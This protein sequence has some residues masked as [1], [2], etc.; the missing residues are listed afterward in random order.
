MAAPT[1]HR[2]PPKGSIECP[3][4]KNHIAVVPYAQVPE[5]YKISWKIVQDDGLLLEADV[6]AESIK[7]FSAF[8][9]AAAKEGDANVQVLIHK[10]DSDGTN[11]QID[12]LVAHIK[13]SISPTPHIPDI[14]VPTNSGGDDVQP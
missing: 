1:N 3:H 6:L 13:K 4:C 10:I 2:M 11:I 7:A 5:S 9:K 14:A 8:L 12:F